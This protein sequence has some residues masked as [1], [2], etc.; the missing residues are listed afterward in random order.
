MTEWSFKVN[1]ESGDLLAHKNTLQWITDKDNDA[2][3]TTR[4]SD[5]RLE[6]V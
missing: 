6:K 4:N 3:K 1:T 5:I 2:F